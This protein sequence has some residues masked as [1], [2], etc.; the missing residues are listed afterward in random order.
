MYEKIQ[1]IERKIVKYEVRYVDANGNKLS[2]PVTKLN[3]SGEEFTEKALQIDGYQPIAE[4]QNVLLLEGNN[5]PVIFT[6]KKEA[7]APKNVQVKYQVKYIDIYENEIADTVTKI[8]FSGKEI[9]EKAVFIEG[10]T[11]RLQSKTVTL[12]AE[13]ND[14]IIFVYLKGNV[15]PQNKQV[16]YQIKFVD[17]NGKEIA[18]PITKVDFINATVIEKAPEIK[19]YIKPQASKTL[20]LTEAQNQSI[21]FVYEKTDEVKTLREFISEKID[22]NTDLVYTD[23]NFAGR[24]EDLK[25]F[26]A[27]SI[28]KRK[29]AVKFYATEEDVDKLYWEL[30]NKPFDGSLVRMARLWTSRDNVRRSETST[31]GVYEYAMGITYHISREQ[32]IETENKIDEIIQKHDLKNKSDYDKAKI[33]YDYLINTTEVNKDNNLGY[34]RYNHSAVLMANAGVCEGYAMAYSRIAERAGLESRFVSGLYYPA[35]DKK[36]QKRYFDAMIPKIQTEVFDKRLNHAWNQVKID[37][38]WY[39]VDSYHGDYYYSNNANSYTYHTFL[40]SDTSIGDDRIWNY[41]FTHKAPEDYKG[42]FVLDKTIN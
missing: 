35:W 37:G 7:S 2:D 3:F 38:Q 5:R 21:V 14:P 29:L 18:D 17:T 13:N 39:H 11:P 24:P 42:K 40:K 33:I 26:V 9:V 34:N 15:T 23:I 28:Y 22:L 8:D 1:E 6:Y 16:K 19:K 4:T 25:D 32:L 41:D 12:S 31:P 30:W 27:K 36:A 10:Y 20:T